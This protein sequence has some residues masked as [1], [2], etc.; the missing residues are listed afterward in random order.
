MVSFHVCVFCSGFC[1]QRPTT[2]FLALAY[3]L[4]LLAS[5]CQS[6]L[7]KS[8]P[9]TSSPSPSQ[10]PRCKPVKDKELLRILGSE[11]SGLLQTHTPIPLCRGSLRRLQESEFLN[12]TVV[13]GLV[14]RK[15]DVPSDDWTA[16]RWP[17]PAECRESVVALPTICPWKITCDYDEN[18]YPPYMYR[19]ACHKPSRF[20][21]IRLGQTGVISRMCPG[22][23]R[24]DCQ[25]V[26]AKVWVLRR[27]RTSCDSRGRERWH[28]VEEEIS[29]ACG[30]PYI[31]SRSSGW[32]DTSPFAKDRTFTTFPAKCKT[33]NS[34]SHG[35]VKL[36]KTLDNK[37][38]SKMEFL[39][40]F[41]A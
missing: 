21:R 7:S 20:T 37:L 40:V 12:L 18:R 22:R 38:T 30:C 32:A 14:R 1:V 5:V 4:S 16:P 6:Q 41:E 35:S 8:A 26:F 39:S 10:T 17:I 25:P 31:P 2:T 15:K 28:R 3:C 33:S 23:P 11:N 24:M 36:I 27:D 29:I 34:R 19:A 9:E 13:N